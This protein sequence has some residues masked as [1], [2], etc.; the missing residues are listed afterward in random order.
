MFEML[1][2]FSVMILEVICN[3]IFFSAFFNNKK[4]I[5]KRR[6]ILFLLI[7]IIAFFAIEFVFK[8]HFIVRSILIV[9]A[10]TAIMYSIKDGDIWKLCV[11]AIIFMFIMVVLDLITLGFIY[12]LFDQFDAS[13]IGNT[14]SGR[15]SV[16]IEKTLLLLIVLSLKMRS[17]KKKGKGLIETEW[18]RFVFFPIF[19]IISSLS[20]AVAFSNIQEMRQANVLYSI[21]FGMVL[22]NIFIFFLINDIIEREVEIKEKEAE[23]VQFR[24]QISIYNTIHESLERQKERAHEFK[25]H[26]LCVDSLFMIKRS[27]LHSRKTKR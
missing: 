17:D 4:T 26:I 3:R 18:I 12:T 25:N 19:T 24:N 7:H 13:D 21:A 20:M 9:L 10:M 27:M 8:D 23:Y 6:S 22:M 14:L 15:L 5:S 2:N 11:A 16:I 1:N